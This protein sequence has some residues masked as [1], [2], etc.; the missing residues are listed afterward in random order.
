MPSN[1]AWTED[2][3][4]F[5]SSGNAFRGLLIARRCDHC[6]GAEGFSPAPS[7][8]NLAGEDQLSVWKQLEDFRSGK[9]I[10]RAMQPIANVLS[11]RDE[12][13][14]AAYFSMLPTANDPQD[15]RSFPQIMQHNSLAPTA[16]R[17]IVFGDGPRGIPPCQSCHGPVGFVKGAPPLAYQNADYLRQQLGNFSSDLRTNDINLRMRSIAR[18][19]TPDEITAV[20]EFYGAA[21]GPGVNPRQ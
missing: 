6:H 1:V 17:L 20:S 15:N 16:I 3:V 18:Q 2:T 8:P 7:I 13:D 12:A 4:A 14:L 19:L 10:S 11:P 9:R 21:L 5:A